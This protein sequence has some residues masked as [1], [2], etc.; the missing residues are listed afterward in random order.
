MENFIRYFR[1]STGIN[2]DQKAPL[3]TLRKEGLMKIIEE[4]N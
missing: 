1:L 2:D 4:R 3:S